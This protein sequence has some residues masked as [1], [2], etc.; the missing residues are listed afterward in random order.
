MTVGGMGFI[1]ER[2]LMMM[3]MM[4]IQ[5]AA[6]H[7]DPPP[8]PPA[9]SSSHTHTL[10]LRSATCTP[11]ALNHREAL[12]HQASLQWDVT[13]RHQGMPLPVNKLRKSRSNFSLVQAA[14]AAAAE[15]LPRVSTPGSIAGSDE[16]QMPAVAE[17]VAPNPDILWGRQVLQALRDG[18]VLDPV[19]LRARDGLL[20]SVFCYTLLFSAIL[21]CSLLFSTIL[22]YSLLFSAV[23]AIL[24]PVYNDL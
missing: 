11:E 8:P 12:S 17:L 2:L 7:P 21:C 13:S 5:S 23:L 24:T 16:W 15:S 1:P 22:C 6:P 14:A 3:M 20:F 18:L 9:D 4:M 10:W 19:L